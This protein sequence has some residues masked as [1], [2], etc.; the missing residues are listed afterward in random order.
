MTAAERRTRIARVERW[1]VLAREFERLTHPYP[2]RGAAL[3]RLEQFQKRHPDGGL[4]N[5][6]FLDDLFQLAIDRGAT[7]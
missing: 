5:A 6:A 1:F 4:I 2:T 3:I 7:L